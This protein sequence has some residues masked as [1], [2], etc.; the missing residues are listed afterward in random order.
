VREIIVLDDASTDDSATVIPAIAAQWNREI[1]FVPNATNS[2][3]V[4]AQWRRAADL[5]SG[6]FVWLAEADDS[7][8]PDFLA[9]TLALLGSDPAIQFAFADSRTIDADGA[10]QWD[11]Y[12][13]Y[14]STVEAGALAQTEVFEARDFVQRFLSVKNLILNVSAV[15]W[16]RD[17]LLRALSVCEDEL[18]T[19]RMAGDWRLYLEALVLPGAK[20]A[21]EAEPLNVH[22]RHATSVTHALNADRHVQEIARCH[23]IALLAFGLPEPVALKQ[24]DYLQAVAGQL[25]AST[26]KPDAVAGPA[27]NGAEAAAIAAQDHEAIESDE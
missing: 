24:A 20:V 16:R 14:Y 15:V 12:K 7:A 26:A 5:A 18:K 13:P 10:A 4:F 19:F 3:S 8:E 11:S 1:S 17:A 21:Y 2:G 6:E 25:G 9:R 22:R 27:E 23:E